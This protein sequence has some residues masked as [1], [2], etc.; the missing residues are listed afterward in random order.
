MPASQQENEYMATLV[1]VIDIWRRFIERQNQEAVV[2]RTESTLD[3]E[4]MLLEH[5]RIRWQDDELQVQF[6]EDGEG[7]AFETVTEDSLASHHQALQ[8]LLPALKKH[9]EPPS[10]PARVS[11]WLGLHALWKAFKAPAVAVPPRV[12]VP[13]PQPFTWKDIA[14]APFSFVNETLKQAVRKLLFDNFIS[15]FIV[16]NLVAFIANRGN[17]HYHTPARTL[18]RT[19]GSLIYPGGTQKPV[20]DAAGHIHLGAVLSMHYHRASTFNENAGGYSLERFQ[21]Q[22]RPGVVLDAIT[23]ANY[24]GTPKDTPLHLV[25]FTGNTG[26]YEVNHENMVVGQLQQFQEANIPV[27]AIEFNYPGVLKST[28]QVRRAQDLFDAGISMVQILLDRGVPANR[29][30]LH[31]VSLGGSIASHVASHFESRGLP[32]AGTYA[33]KTFSSTTNVAISYLQRIPY[34]G[35]LL[36][37]LVRPLVAFA[38]WSTGW[39]MDTAAHFTSLT[40]AEYSVVR[41]PKFARD[42]NNPPIDDPVLA[43]YSSLHESWRLR[44]RRFLHKHGWRGYDET[45]YKTLNHQR[46]MQVYRMEGDSDMPVPAPDV[47]GHSREHFDGIV[48]QHRVP[49]VTMPEAPEGEAPLCRPLRSGERIHQFFKEC[50]ERESPAATD[51]DIIPISSV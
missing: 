16:G 20:I 49:P 22:S 33:S 9:L 24:S 35:G 6:P 28:G 32:L 13:R 31:G 27:R 44:F 2:H 7:A 51:R 39:Q 42:S 34:V 21:V 26:C 17:P 25:F 48:L 10:F 12:I 11:R 18:S 40:H 46:K 3:G 45:T 15:R 19:L 29:I 23:T 1:E 38:L 47:C 5:M 41:S 30:G 43:H 36:G 8:H 50:I 37:M 4:Q 14:L